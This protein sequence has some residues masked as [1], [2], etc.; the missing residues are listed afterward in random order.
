[1]QP[2]LPGLPVMQDQRVQPELPGLPGLRVRP[3]RQDP[4]EHQEKWDRQGLRALQE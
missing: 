2:E 3:A 1:V 4:Q